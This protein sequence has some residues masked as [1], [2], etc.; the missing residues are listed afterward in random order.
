MR[1]RLRL[2]EFD[3]RFDMFTDYVPYDFSYPLRLPCT[4]PYP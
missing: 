2:L 3:R 1:P 4:M